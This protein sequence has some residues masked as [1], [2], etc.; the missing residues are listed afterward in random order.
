MCVMQHAGLK[1]THAGFDILRNLG[2]HLLHHGLLQLNSVPTST[3]PTHIEA[4][5]LAPGTEGADKDPRHC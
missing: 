4:C 1:T 5:T 3:V 2:L